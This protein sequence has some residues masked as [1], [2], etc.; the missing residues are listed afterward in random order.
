MHSDAYAALKA[1][2]IEL[3]VYAVLVVAYFFVVL[4]LLGH[5]LNDLHTHRRIAYA[6]V[7]IALIIGQAVVLES[8]T[9]WLMRML[10]GGRSE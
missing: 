1:F 2:L 9:T 4:H 7:A 8:L 10:R 5:W 6:F 3:L